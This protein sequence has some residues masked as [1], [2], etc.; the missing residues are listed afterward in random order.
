[1][2]AFENATT[3]FHNCES[4]KGWDACK[5]YVTENAQFNAQSEP[6]TDVIK[7]EDYVN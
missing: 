6:L 4:A 7:V 5:D 1:M 2:K 3:F